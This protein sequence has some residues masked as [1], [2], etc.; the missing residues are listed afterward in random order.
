MQRAFAQH[1]ESAEEP[2]LVRVGL[3]AGEPIAEEEDLYGTAVNEAAWITASAKG[4]EILVSDVVR[5]L[6]EGKVFLFVDRGETSLKGF[7]DPV[8][9]FE[10]RWWEEG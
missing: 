7:E 4:C 10:V 1:N 5:L 8:R 3:N 6:A 2:I 9:L